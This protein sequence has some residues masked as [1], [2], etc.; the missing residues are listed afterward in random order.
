ML[1]LL[2]GTEGSEY[3]LAI[4]ESIQAEHDYGAYQTAGR[5]AWLF[6]EDNFCMS[7]IQELPRL[8]KT[9]PDWAGDFMVS[10]AN[11]EGTEHESVIK[12]FNRHLKSVS[13]DKQNV[14]LEYINEQEKSGWFEHRVGV[15]GCNA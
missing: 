4:F 5:A 7:L 11:G 10:I 12:T 15:L 1:D 2:D 8:I 9:F 3:A 13:S 14:I 6:G